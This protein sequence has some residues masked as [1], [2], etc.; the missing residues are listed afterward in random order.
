MSQ[1]AEVQLT[2][3]SVAAISDPSVVGQNIRDGKRKILHTQPIVS[4]QET[5]LMGMSNLSQQKIGKSAKSK[6]VRAKTNQKAMNSVGLQPNG[7]G[8]SNKSGIFVF[9]SNAEQGPCGT[10]NYFN[11]KVNPR[12]NLT[13]MGKENTGSEHCNSSDGRQGE[14]GDLLQGEGD[15]D[16]RRN[17]TVDKARP[18]GSVG[19]VRNRFDDGVEEP[20][21][22]NR[23]KQTTGLS[24]IEG[25]SVGHNP[26]PM[27]EILDGSTCSLGAS[28]GKLRA[29]SDRIQHAELRKISIR[30]RGG[31]DE[32]NDF[33]KVDADHQFS[34]MFIDG[35]STQGESYSICRT[36][37]KRHDPSQSN[38]RSSGD[39]QAHGNSNPGDL[40]VEEKDV[41]G[42][43]VEGH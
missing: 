2:Q 21:P 39:N 40:G 16:E 13:S 34:G 20:V 6:G 19:L 43:D 24:A 4:Q 3:A 9:G 22:F 25:R 1:T 26:E 31:V 42:M 5:N 17:N 41:G 12:D 8:P 33:N 14:L 7:V 11:S 27:V 37:D 23:E 30:S 38:A 32:A 36:R 15:S 18:N 28:D 35:Q 10:S 29:I